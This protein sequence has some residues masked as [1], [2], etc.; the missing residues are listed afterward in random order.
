MS[1]NG[2]RPH[3]SS[4]IAKFCSLIKK[5]RANKPRPNTTRQ[6]SQANATAIRWQVQHYCHWNVQKTKDTVREER[7]QQPSL[8]H[9]HRSC[10][11]QTVHHRWLQCVALAADIW[12]TAIDHDKASKINNSKLV[13]FSNSLDYK[14]ELVLITNLTSHVGSINIYKQVDFTVSDFVSQIKTWHHIVK[15][16]G[17]YLPF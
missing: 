14:K 10:G 8:Q 17:N 6:E 16:T 2:S 1:P 5:E 9:W 3:S 7:V 11:R 15:S 13:L 4:A 12:C